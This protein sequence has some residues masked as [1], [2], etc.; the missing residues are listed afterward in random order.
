[1][2]TGRLIRSAAGGPRCVGLRGHPTR[3]AV[4]GFGLGSSL[5]LAVSWTPRADPAAWVTRHE[6][7]GTDAALGLAVADSAHVYVTG[8][9]EGTGTGFDIL[10]IRYGADGTAIWT[11]RYDGAASGDDVPAAIAFNALGNVFVAGSSA[12]SGG[13]DCVT[14]KY[15]PDGSLAWVHRY[16]GPAA[17]ADYA[18]SLAVTEDGGVVVAGAA[19]DTTGGMNQL[20]LKLTSAG[21]VDWLRLDD[22][23]GHGDDELRGVV[24]LPLGGTA[25]AGIAAD[26]SG[27]GDIVTRVVTAGGATVWEHSYD[28]PGHK[29][30]W[31]LAIAADGTGRVFVSGL[32]VGNGQSSDCVALRFASGGTLDWASHLDGV[33]GDFD[34]GVAVSPDGGGGAFVAGLTFGSPG[35]FDYLTAHFLPSGS[36]DWSRTLDGAVSGLDEVTTLARGAMG[37]LLVAGRSA[38]PANGEDFNVIAYSVTGDSV[39]R[40]SYGGPGAGDDAPAAIATDGQGSVYVAGASAGAGTG[41]DFVTV[42][43]DTSTS[44]VSVPD[45]SAI[46]TVFNAVLRSANPVRSIMAVE[47]WLPVSATLSA[48]LFDIQ[49]RVV[50]SL[51]RLQLPPG[52]H[53]ARMDVSPVATGVYFWR[54]HGNLGSAPVKVVLKAVVV[55]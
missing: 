50:A 2:P 1:M 29:D 11:H 47:L 34:A 48:E 18:R 5:L 15:N 37:L 30:D 25:T 20:L 31:P 46:P 3:S 51:P 54:L 6:G 43:F 42:R 24:L 52:T 10:T 38:S 44:V 36:L 4:I 16:D 35:G 39:W 32:S 55:R 22:G 12:G 23:A 9:S 28:G 27:L 49:G 13:T 41:L 17:A 40:W 19:Y 53:V 26:T 7:S 33:A 45:R 8:A 14:L 21:A